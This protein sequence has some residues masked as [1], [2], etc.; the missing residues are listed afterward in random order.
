MENDD[1]GNSKFFSIFEVETLVNGRCR[2][3]IDIGNYKNDALIL[4][5]VLK[6]SLK[7]S[8]KFDK[9]S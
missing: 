8:F 2:F 1:A 7:F 4:L 6:S 3:K 9:V 5:N